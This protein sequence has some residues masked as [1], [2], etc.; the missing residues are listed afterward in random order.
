MS[1][2]ERNYTTALASALDAYLEKLVTD[3][4]ERTYTPNERKQAFNKLDTSRCFDLIKRINDSSLL[5]LEVKVTDDNKTFRSYNNRQHII[6]MILRKAN[7]PIEYCYNLVNDYSKLR[8]EQVLV[9][10]NTSEPNIVCDEN[11]NI[12]NY[13]QHINL[14]NLIDNMIE[15]GSANGDSFNSLLSEDFIKNLQDTNIQL[16]FF[17]YNANSEEILTFNTKELAELY[18]VFSEK[19][20]NQSKIDFKTANTNEIKDFFIN[21]HK[22][23]AHIINNYEIEKFIKEDEKKEVKSNFRGIRR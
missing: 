7:I 5:I 12:I 9:N 22:N 23:I 18:Y 21:T 16:L 10:S 4:F 19:I 20:T 13:N 15:D 8:N 14:K 3:T 2:E 6:N 17:A 11:G 1:L